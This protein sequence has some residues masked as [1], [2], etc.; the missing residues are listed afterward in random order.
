MNSVFKPILS[1]RLVFK[2]KGHLFC[3]R[4]LS[5]R[6]SLSADEVSRYSR[7]MLCQEVGKS[8]QLALK[9]T[10]VLIVGCGGL[11]CPASLYLTAAG[12][13]RIGLVDNDVVDRSNLH[14]QVL[15][16]ET[17]VGKLKTDSAVESLKSINS[18]VILEPIECRLNRT[19]ASDIISKYDIIIDGTD[20]PMA[21]YL[22]S[23]VCVLNKKPLVS[24]SALR[25]DGQLTVYNYDSNTPC[26]RCLFPTPPPAG[27]VT[28]CNDG[29][30]IGVIPGIIGDMQALET[31]KIA[32]GRR[33]SYAGQLLLFDGLNGSFKSIKLRGKSADCISC[34]PNATIG[35]ELMDYEEFCGVQCNQSQSLKI[36]APEERMSCKE[37]ESNYLNAKI[38]HLLIDVRP[39]L[40]AEITKL[41]NALSIPLEELQ[42]GNGFEILEDL[43][44]KEMNR[45]KNKVN[46]I[47]M[48]RRD[49][50]GGL[51]AWV[52]EIDPTFPMY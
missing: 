26:Y 21:R 6:M 28:N 38:D 17:R 13:G 48:C 41:E 45:N 7:Q 50:T 8:G 47:F 3:G 46:V 37:Y 23:D 44:D 43:I 4:R 31:I 12:I 51:E 32:I 29:G 49:I 18:N 1:F 16:N 33:P 40:Q 27:T 11:G 39:K 42:K 30:V 19:N 9:A 2:P 34:G 20:N 36:L 24:G 52:K 5:S 10:S 35:P 25:F 22:L 14:R 15:H